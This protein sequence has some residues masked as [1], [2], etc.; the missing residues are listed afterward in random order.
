VPFLIIHESGQPDRL[1]EVATHKL[2]IGRGNFSDLVLPNVSVS[3]Q[4]AQLAILASGG[5]MLTTLADDNPVYEDDREIPMVTPIEHG[6]KFRIGRYDLTFLEEARLDLFSLQQLSEL[7]RFV[8]RGGSETETHVISSTLHKQLLLVE[9]RR[10]FG[11]LENAEGVRTY[12]GAEPREL[13]PDTDLPC[14]GR[15]GSG[16]AARITWMGAHHLIERASIFAKLAING[17]PQKQ[18]ILQPGDLIEVNGAT[19][20]YRAERPPKK[21]RPKPSAKRPMI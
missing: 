13:G 20:T 21:A 17:E 12:L 10:E 8:R 9:I 18:R 2:I 16:T 4:H 15:W 3:R 14:P 7:P 1:F 6:R 11:A 5:G 19:Y